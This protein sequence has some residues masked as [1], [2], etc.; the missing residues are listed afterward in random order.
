MEWISVKEG[1]P[2]IDTTVLVSDGSAITLSE[3]DKNKEWVMYDS[4]L[5]NWV[6]HW[7]PLPLLPINEHGT[8][9]ATQ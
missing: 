3:L 4:V 9:L 5:H 7:M 8:P 1:F 2:E 6:T